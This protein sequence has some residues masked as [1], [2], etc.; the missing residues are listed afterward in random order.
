MRSNLTS[1]TASVLLINPCAHIDF[2]HRALAVAC[3]HVVDI[4]SLLNA[5]KFILNPFM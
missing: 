1:Q 3:I 4:M 5:R 2:V